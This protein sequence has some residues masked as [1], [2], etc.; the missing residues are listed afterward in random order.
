MKRLFAFLTVLIPFMAM[1]QTLK[2]SEYETPM[3]PVK[4]TYLYHASMIIEAG[5]KMIYV[6]PYS[7]VGD[8]MD[9]PKADLV[10]ITHE[11]GDHFD[12]NALDYITTP[13]T[14]TIA[15]KLVADQYDKV[16]K[17]MANG[18]VA[19]WNGIKIEAVPA[20]NIQQMRSPGVPYHPKGDGNGYI[21]NFGDFRIYIAADT[22][23]IPEMK[24]LGKID[25]AFLPK[26]L[27]YT[28]SDEQF[29]EAAELIKPKVLY[30]YHYQRVNKKEVQDRL[31]G[32]EIK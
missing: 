27:P 7:S 1:A 11:H 20:Y 6:D 25:I 21:L 4:I 8:Y 31:P 28:M 17:V 12:R 14:Y 13:E 22:E 32:I 16:S 26:M 5:G 3:G 10:L 24:N 30:P 15:T 18:D 19:E 2:T 29:Y 23:L 9:Y